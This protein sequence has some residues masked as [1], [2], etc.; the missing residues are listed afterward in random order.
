MHSTPLHVRRDLGRIHGGFPPLSSYCT[1]YGNG[2]RSTS[3]CDQVSGKPQV[4]GS[5]LEAKLRRDM[6]GRAEEERKQVKSEPARPVGS[7]QVVAPEDPAF[8]CLLA[9]IHRT[10][11]QPATADVLTRHLTRYGPAPYEYQ[12]EVPFVHIL[13]A[14]SSDSPVFNSAKVVPCAPCAVDDSQTEGKV[15]H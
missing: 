6:S 5:T 10:E 2:V 9:L 8:P 3:P 4:S 1:V 14:I 15:T 13:A 7:F 11:I 12:R